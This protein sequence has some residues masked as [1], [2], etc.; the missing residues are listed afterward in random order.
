MKV[1]PRDFTPHTVG[2]RMSV[3]VGLLW[4]VPVLV[5]LFLLIVL[6]NVSRSMWLSGRNTGRY[7]HSEVSEIYDNIR[8]NW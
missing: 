2:Y 5:I 8:R 4:A 1:F 6:Q 7:V 3:L